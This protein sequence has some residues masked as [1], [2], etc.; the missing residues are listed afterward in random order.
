MEPLREIQNCENAQHEESLPKS[1]NDCLMS[2]IN[3]YIN[4]SRFNIKIRVC[5]VE[6]IAFLSILYCVSAIFDFL[7]GGENLFHKS[8]DENQ[9]LLKRLLGVLKKLYGK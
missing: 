7:F 6:N 4:E 3:Y 9:I 5:N 2:F 1:G 8:A